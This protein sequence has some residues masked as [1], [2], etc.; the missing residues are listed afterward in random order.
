MDNYLNVFVSIDD[1][2]LLGHKVCIYSLYETQELP[3]KIWLA[4]LGISEEVK[5]ELET[6]YQRLDITYEIIDIPM[7]VKESLLRI[8]E[9]K[10]DKL[11]N[12]SLSIETYV[13]LFITHLIPEDVKKILWLDADTIVVKS[14]TSFWEKDFEGN[15]ISGV[16]PSAIYYD[17]APISERWNILNQI[18]RNI[19]LI[20]AGVIKFNLEGIRKSNNYINSSLE[21][22]TEY[23]LNSK[24]PFF[25]QGIINSLFR[26]QIQ[27]LDIAYNFDFPI[28]T[29]NF[30]DKWKPYRND[31]DKIRYYKKF[32]EA[33]IIHYTSIIKPWHLS[34]EEAINN[35]ISVP[36]IKAKERMNTLLDDKTFKV[37]KKNYKEFYEILKN[38]KNNFNKL[39]LSKINKEDS[40]LELGCGNGSFLSNLLSSIEN[41]YTGIDI[42][43]VRIFEAKECFKD[44]DNLKFLEMDINSNEAKSLL[45]NN[46]VLVMHGYLPLFSSYINFSYKEIINLYNSNNCDYRLFKEQILKKQL[47]PNFFNC[48]GDNDSIKLIKNFIGNSNNRVYLGFAYLPDYLRILPIKDFYEEIQYGAL[49]FDIATGFSFK[50]NTLGGG[51]LLEIYS[52]NKD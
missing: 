11:K 33:S 1:N 23:I 41:P 18:K 34:E 16:D 4:S 51:T 37:G 31:L 21:E 8:K 44:K 27:G 20:N 36:W 17:W 35:E 26:N 46:N 48:L 43:P 7:E 42:S 3:I 5:K 40:I 52:V 10:N 50:F 19:L 49:L 38:Y 24:E 12:C 47:S 29:N 28:W 14:L 25:D 30:N 45:Q 9:S 39:L 2:F 15:L 6:F 13:R 22:L 32:R